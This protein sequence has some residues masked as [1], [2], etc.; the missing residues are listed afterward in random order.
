MQ[1]RSMP[2]ST[3]ASNMLRSHYASYKLDQFSMTIYEPIGRHDPRVIHEFTSLRRH[4]QLTNITINNPT[5]LA[6]DYPQLS[7]YTH[8]E[9]LRTQI[10]SAE[11]TIGLVGCKPSSNAELGIRLNLHWP[12]NLSRWKDFGC[13][14]RFY[15]HGKLLRFGP[16]PGTSFATDQTGEEVEKWDSIDYDHEN[17]T[18]GSVHFWS[19]FWARKIGLS[20]S[21]LRKANNLMIHAQSL[22]GEEVIKYEQ[23]AKEV[24]T[25][26]A[27]SFKSLTALQEISATVRSTGRKERLLLI[28][29]RFE[30]CLDEN[31][32]GETSWRNIIVNQ[33]NSVAPAALPGA[34]PYNVQPIKEESKSGI[35]SQV[36]WDDEAIAMAAGTG[37]SSVSLQQ[38]FE[39]SQAL[40]LPEFSNM[41]M[42]GMS[43]ATTVGEHL[44]SQI[45]TDNDFDF[46]GGHIQLNLGQQM[47]DQSM[48]LDN[49]HRDTAALQTTAM[50]YEHNSQDWHEMSFNDPYFSQTQTAG[51]N[52]IQ[53]YDE[54]Q[55]TPFSET[56]A[57]QHPD[58]AIE[59]SGHEQK[60]FSEPFQHLLSAS[61]HVEAS[62]AALTPEEALRQHAYLEQAASHSLS[63]H[64]QVEGFDGQH[65]LQPHL[66]EQTHGIEEC[67]PEHALQS[68]EFAARQDIA[69]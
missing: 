49:F 43:A 5:R 3:P 19:D 9:L 62:Q 57:Q 41:D 36:V 39:P 58:S 65:E 18:L 23:E 29:W 33:D 60:H 47:A 17:H 14:V 68:I 34:M 64:H 35:H 6:A 30:Q 44:A 45:Y 61:A 42:Q 25:N 31:R 16:G 38:A 26:L 8:E 2:Y 12:S 67:G 51:Y 48:V 20:M 53:A 40:T 46:T 7:S 56:G 21:E 63:P 11:A 37:M 24:K 52:T 10:I 66:Y 54:H 15:D 55:D 4:P 32:P 50:G 13:L 22:F 1:Q 27:N 69:L 28:C 59:M